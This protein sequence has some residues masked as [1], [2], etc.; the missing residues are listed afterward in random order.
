VATCL[1][2]GCHVGK[3]GQSTTVQMLLKCTE[4]CSKILFPIFSKIQIKVF[5]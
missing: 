5:Y 1:Q 4:N 2:W 3:D